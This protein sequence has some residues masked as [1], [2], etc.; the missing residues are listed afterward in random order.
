MEEWHEVGPNGMGANLFA[1]AE[2]PSVV[3][4]VLMAQNCALWEARCSACILNLSCVA[5]LH[6]LETSRPCADGIESRF[7]SQI[8]SLSQAGITLNRLF[9]NPGH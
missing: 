8:D 4:K 6:I 3:H 5:W 1:I 7:I 9:G 2:Q